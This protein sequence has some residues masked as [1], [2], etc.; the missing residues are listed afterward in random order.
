[1]CEF[2]HPNPHE[3]YCTEH[4]VLVVAGTEE[5]VFCPEGVEDDQ[6]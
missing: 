3:W 1:M 4:D 5:P 2:E 6:V